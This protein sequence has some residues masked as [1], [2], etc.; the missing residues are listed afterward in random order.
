MKCIAIT[1]LFFLCIQAAAQNE[2]LTAVSQYTSLSVQQIDS[3]AATI[4]STKGLRTA[5]SDGEVRPAGKKKPKGGFSDTYYVKPVTNQLLMVF[6]EVYLFTTDLTT[7]YFYNNNLILVKK[8]SHN[9]DQVEL[10]K[11]RYYFDNG[12]LFNKLEEGKPLSKPEVFLQNAARYL[13]D[14]KT[15]FPY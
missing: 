6:N 9:K 7:Y 12:V 5:I 8:T 11:G 4:D 14:A 1:T 15:M 3:L 10:L 13:K 2:P